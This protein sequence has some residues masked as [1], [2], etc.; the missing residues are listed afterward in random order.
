MLFKSSGGFVRYLLLP[1]ALLYWIGIGIRNWLFDRHI[2]KSSAFG[3]PVICVGNLAVG[4]TGKSPMVELL[5][6]RLKGRYRVATLSRGYKRKTRGYTLAQSGSTAL[7]IGDEPMLFHLKFPDVP[8]AVGE[9]RLEAIPQLLHDRPETRVII[10]DDAFQH[11]SIRAGMNILLTE[12]NRLFTDDFYLPVGR[13]RDQ[14]KS[15]RRANLIIVSKCD[16][17]MQTGEKDA[18]LRK[19][20]PLARQHVYF[21]TL[22]YGRI[23]H[24]IHREE[25]ALDPSTG[26]LLVTGIANPE[27]LEKYVMARARNWDTLRFADHHI[28]TIDDLRQCRN[29]LGKINAQEK[30][31]LTTEKDAVRLEKFRQE[32]ELMPVYVVPVRHRFLFGQENEFIQKVVSFLEGFKILEQAAPVTKEE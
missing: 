15:Y 20:K 28:F 18:I 3:L 17:D 5:V 26:V 19:I 24:I 9:K 22:E 14:K 11:R 12:R 31:I 23:S 8:V 16:P 6:E 27:P 13:L 7:E 10:L 21:T 2:L 25:I 1:F 29:R 4:G 32:L 30:I